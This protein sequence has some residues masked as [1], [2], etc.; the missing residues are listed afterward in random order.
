M[1]IY[2]FPYQNFTV[3]YQKGCCSGQRREPMAAYYLLQQ[4]IIVMACVLTFPSDPCVGKKAKVW[5]TVNK[6]YSWQY[7]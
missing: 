6:F 5:L 2:I 7:F 4:F 1:R 3:G